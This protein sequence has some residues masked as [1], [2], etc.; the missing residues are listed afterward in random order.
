[1]AFH[2]QKCSVLRVTRS[3]TPVR[4][5]YRVKGHILE[6]QDSTKYLGVDLSW[7]DHTDRICKKA[8]SMLGFLLWCTNR[9]KSG[10]TGAPLYFTG[11]PL[12]FTGAPVLVMTLSQYRCTAITLNQLS[13]Q[14]S[15]CIS[16]DTGK[17]SA[18]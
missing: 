17:S 11:P 14:K 3:R 5:S 9:V 10:D 7:R 13:N 8:N 18:V 15:A 2:P 6:L 12:Y 1:M 16:I 4:Y